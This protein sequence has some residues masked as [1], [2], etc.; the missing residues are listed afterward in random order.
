MEQAWNGEENYFC[1]GRCEITVNGA[2]DE[3]HSFSCA[4]SN[5]VDQAGM[6]DPEERGVEGCVVQW[7]KATLLLSDSLAVNSSPTTY[8]GWVTCLNS[9]PISS[10]VK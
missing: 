5:W 2:L 9:A 6:G 10:F 8:L 3:N 4:R 7:L 1:G